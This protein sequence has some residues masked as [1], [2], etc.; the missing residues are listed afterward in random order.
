M[1]VAAE[2][3]KIGLRL[4]VAAAGTQLEL[5]KIALED[6]NKFCKLDTGELRA[7]SYK[8]SNLVLG[9]LVWRTNYARHAYYLGEPSRTKNPLASR[10]WAHKAAAAYGSK[11][12]SFARGR[13][14]QINLRS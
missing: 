11:W 12:Y 3:L 6:C 2:M 13:L 1:N 10:L 14:L 8:A 7:S 9:R 4:A 5:S